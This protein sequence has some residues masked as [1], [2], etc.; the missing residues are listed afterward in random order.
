[1]EVAIATSGTSAVCNRGGSL[2]PITIAAVGFGAM[3]AQQE[4]SNGNLVRI[5]QTDARS[6]IVW[7][8]D[9]V[10]H[11]G[12]IVEPAIGDDWEITL[13]SGKVILAECFPFGQQPHWRWTDRF[14][15]A[16]RIFV[17]VE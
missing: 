3:L 14:E 5:N 7:P 13:P 12:K 15:T 17:K 9:F 10:N 4:D 2:P 1:M 11:T 8:H 16:Y 6:L